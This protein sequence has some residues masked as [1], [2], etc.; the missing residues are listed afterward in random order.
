MLCFLC[1][2]N[3]LQNCKA[4]ASYAATVLGWK[5][6]HLT[7]TRKSMQPCGIIVTDTPLV[8]L[9]GHTLLYKMANRQKFNAAGRRMQNQYANTFPNWHQNNEAY[10]MLDPADLS[11]NISVWDY[12]YRM[13]EAYVNSKL[14]CSEYMHV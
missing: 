2:L 6:I 4:A 12:I 10:G 13:P 9:D 7:Q 5:D 14:L 11:R 1:C 8:H 3:I